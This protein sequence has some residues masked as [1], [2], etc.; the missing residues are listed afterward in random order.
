MTTQD[1]QAV[2]NRAKQPAHSAEK[3]L[4]VIEQ[5]QT[6]LVELTDAARKIGLAADEIDDS[7][8]R[9]IG[10]AEARW[11]REHYAAVDLRFATQKTL[12]V[13]ARDESDPRV[14][15]VVSSPIDTIGRFEVTGELPVF[16]QLW[17]NYRNLRN[18]FDH[19]ADCRGGQ[20]IFKERVGSFPVRRVGQVYD[21][22]A[23][24]VASVQMPSGLNEAVFSSICKAMAWLLMFDAQLLQ[25][26]IVE[27]VMSSR[28]EISDR[29]GILWAP[30]LDAWT[31]QAEP[32]RPA[33][34]PAVLIRGGY[35]DPYLVCFFD[36]PNEKPIENLIREFSRGPVS[37]KKK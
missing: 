21:S 5:L 37:K 7:R 12:H 13:F 8:Q 19:G 32:L 26:G 18:F 33:G 29:V 31:F 9:L 17:N 23:N 27:P 6:S 3:P 35:R 34:D 1:F 15:K 25:Y 10:G 36:T 14:A 4:A 24:I 11:M 20:F 2:L 30:T 28:R 16:V 22:A